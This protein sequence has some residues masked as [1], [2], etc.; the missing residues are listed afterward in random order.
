MTGAPW[1]VPLR[2]GRRMAGRGT[3]GDNSCLDRRTRPNGSFIRTRGDE[4]MARVLNFNDTRKIFEF[5]INRISKILNT[6][7]T[8]RLHKKLTYYLHFFFQMHL[9][10]IA[11]TLN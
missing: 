2:Y 10:L 3:A 5:C 7:V 6:T 1:L 8:Y 11:L 9:Q 4:P